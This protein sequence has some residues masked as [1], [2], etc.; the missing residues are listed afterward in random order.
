MRTNRRSLRKRE[1]YQCT[2]PARHGA[3][4]SRRTLLRALASASLLIQAGRAITK[5]APLDSRGEQFVVAGGWVLS[6]ED[7]SVLAPHA[8]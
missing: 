2:D 6:A 3:P 5:P 4:H 1:C 7:L 8:A